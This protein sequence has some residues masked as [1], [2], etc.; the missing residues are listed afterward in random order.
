MALSAMPSRGAAD[1]RCLASSRL[2]DDELFFS[3]QPVYFYLT[4]GCN[5]ACRHCWIAPQVPD[6]RTVYPSLP[7]DSLRHDHRSEAKPLGL[8]R[9]QAHRRRAAAPPAHHR[10]ARSSCGRE[11]LGL[12]IETNG[13]L[14]TPEIV[15]EIAAVQRAPL[16]RSALTGPTRKPTSGCAG[17]TAPSKRPEQAIRNLVAAGLRPQIIMTL[18]RTTW[19]EIE[20]IIRLAEEL[21][22]GSVKF[23]I[24]QPTAP[25]REAAPRARTLTI[26]ELLDLGR[27]D[28]RTTAP[29]QTRSLLRHPHAFQ[30]LSRIARGKRRRLRPLQHHDH[31]RCPLQRVLRPLRHRRARSRVG[32]WPGGGRPPGREGMGRNRPLLNELREGLPFAAG[33]RLRSLPDE[34]PLPRLLSGAELLPDARSLGA[35]LVL[36]ASGTGGALSFIAARHVKSLW[37]RH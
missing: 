30:P 5:L 27:F 26:G 37:T 23:N 20:D 1:S 4:E 16:S 22:A 33:R 28:R 2:R 18:M 24:V 34:A 10:P 21:G 9:R 32:L 36:R 35:V 7:Y 15:E 12:T 6:G 3:P 31:P 8:G 11:D 13:V 25:R 29:L 19:H 17:W 14:C